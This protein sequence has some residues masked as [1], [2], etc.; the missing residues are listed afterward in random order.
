MSKNYSIS[1]DVIAN[2][3]DF[4]DSETI[5]ERQ[6]MTNYLHKKA[7][8]TPHLFSSIGGLKCH[9][10]DFFI[11]H[12]TDLATIKLL[13]G[14]M[15]NAWR[16]RKHRQIN[17]KTSLSI[18]LDKATAVKFSQMCSK[19]TQAEVVTQLITGD[20]VE[21][22]KHKNDLEARLKQERLALK[23]AQVALKFEKMQSKL[24]TSIKEPNATVDNKLIEELQNGIATLYDLIVTTHD[25]SG[26]VDDKLLLQATKIYNDTFSR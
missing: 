13:A 2:L 5:T 10:V 9:L 26:K 20:Y 24:T 22:S 14:A 23:A 7:I 12:H 3:F 19:Q 15:R 18:S 11:E 17:G 21:F 8:P 4:L 16:V 25:Q 6:W 1:P